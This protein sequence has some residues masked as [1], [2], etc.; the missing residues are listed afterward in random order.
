VPRGRE[1]FISGVKSGVN[2]T[3]AFFINRV[4][5]DGPWD[6]RSLLTAIELVTAR[7]G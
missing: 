2:G 4:R 7:V 3:P 1:D 6:L 5:H